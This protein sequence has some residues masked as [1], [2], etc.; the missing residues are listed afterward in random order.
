[1]AKAIDEPGIHR[2]VHDVLS[3]TSVTFVDE[4]RDSVDAP[5]RHEIEG[6]RVSQRLV[7]VEQ[8]DGRLGIFLNESVR[9]A[10][11]LEAAVGARCRQVE[12]QENA[13]A[14]CRAQ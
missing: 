7:H 11:G 14:F 2:E 5:L 6:R 1:M 12:L 13:Y 8:F 10:D 4:F 9:P 3:A